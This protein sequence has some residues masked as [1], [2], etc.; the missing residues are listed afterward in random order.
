MNLQDE[1]QDLFLSSLKF[2]NKETGREFSIPFLISLGIFRF[3][4]AF[5]AR[6][7]YILKYSKKNAEGAYRKTSINF[8]SLLF[9][10]K[11]VTNKKDITDAKI[12]CDFNQNAARLYCFFF[13]ASNIGLAIAFLALLIGCF[14]ENPFIDA[15]YLLSLIPV[16]IHYFALCFFMKDKTFEAREDNK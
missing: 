14:I 12:K 11:L 8:K 9:R 6:E 10:R 15:V 3:E 4:R 13:T 2:A 5:F 1:V 7:K 16:T